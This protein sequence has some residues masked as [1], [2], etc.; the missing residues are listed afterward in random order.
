MNR[1]KV[2]VHMY[3]S[4]DGKIDGDY[5]SPES[6]AYYSDEL[7]RL[8][9]ADGN[10]RQTIQM[11]AAPSK[12]DLTQYS[13]EKIDYSDWIPDVH[14]ATWSISFDRKGVCGWEKNYFAYNGRKMHAVE[15]VTKQASLAYLAFLR[16]LNIPYIVSGEND[17]NL[18]E[19]LIKLKQY[20]K[21]ETLALCGGARIDGV[22]LQAH[23]VDQIS[24]V[25]AP[26]V[27]GDSK[28]KSAFDTVG[29]FV[30]DRFEIAQFKKLA[31]GGLHLIFNKK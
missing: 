26:Y 14:S 5:T 3:V 1:A 8:S 15:V 7:F 16:S 29:Q 9:N 11:Y 23:L 28:N 27:N 31:D 10:G 24:L 17:F 12:V 20:F 18:N 30:A 13:T 22:F 2:I 19:V 4:I 21:I 6:S 25:I